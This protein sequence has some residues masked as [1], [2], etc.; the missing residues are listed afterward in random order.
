MSDR[1]PPNP[2]A[3]PK[4]RRDK[5][6]PPEGGDTA[7][8]RFE[9]IRQLRAHEYVADQIRRHIALRVVIPGEGLP[10]ERELARMFGVGRPTIQHALRLLEADGLVEARR[11]RYGG[12]FV[13]E[14]TQDHATFD[15]L[16]VRVMRRA[17]E[18]GELLEYRKMV[19]PAVAALAAANRT[20][21]DL[22]AMRQAID[23]MDRA[24]TE[25]DYMRYDTAFHIAV[26]RATQNT[27]LTRAIE[28]LRM[29]LND[30][31]TMLPESDTWHGRISNEHQTL[32]DAIA[33][34][35]VQAARCAMEVHVAHSEQSLRVLLSLLNRRKDLADGTRKSIGERS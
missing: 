15:D 9:P 26:A 24:T 22:A 16:I 14:P 5:Q 7:L 33:E 25:P 21:S 1:Q 29:A 3:E 32:L 6:D 34:S 13:V 28:D 17:G 4:G 30:A 12:T 18:L 23:S 19:D 8:V 20:K 10:P 35:D 2:A 31:I 27:V 11:G